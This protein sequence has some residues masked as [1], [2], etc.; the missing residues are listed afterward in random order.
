M[1]PQ[2][3]LLLQHL[4]LNH[5]Y[6]LKDRKNMLLF[7]FPTPQNIMFGFLDLVKLMFHP[8][9]LKRDKF[10]FRNN[11]F[12][13]LC[14]NHKMLLLGHQVNMKTLSLVYTVLTLF[15]QE[16]L[17][18]IIPNFQHHFQVFQKMELQ[19]NQE[20]LVLV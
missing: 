17:T 15:L 8:L 3:V 6:M 19:L 14:S 20:T 4:N 16:L 7:F 11:Q 2:M 10:L 18:S 13:V 1:S 5:Q 12:L 9:V